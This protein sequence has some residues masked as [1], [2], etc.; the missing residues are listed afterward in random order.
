M[1]READAPI[2]AAYRDDPAINVFQDWDLPY[3]LERATKR[4]AEQAGFDTIIP[5]GWMNLAME[6][7]G[8]LIGDLACHVDE[9][10]HVAEIGYT[11]RAE[12]HGHGFAS[13]GAGA[14]VDHILAT[15]EVH[16]IGASLDPRNIASMRVLEA[17]G[18][19]FESFARQS[20][21]LRGRWDD[22]LR[23]A[24]LRDDRA[25]WLARPRTPP[26]SLE[27]A[28]VTPDDAHLWGRLRTHHSQ[29][30]FVSPMAL[31]FRDALFPEAIDGATVVPW[32]RGVLADGD[33][34]A[35]VMIAEVTEHHPEPYLWRLLVDRMHQRRGVGSR[36][37][38]MLTDRLRAEG[39]TTLLTS[40]GQGRGS[41]EPFYLGLG[42]IPTG[43]VVDGEIEAR[44][45][46]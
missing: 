11:L 33:R 18:M 39:H 25:A 1:M 15:T 34:V 46:L 4:L 2:V 21:A 8:E 7:D 40:W 36:V 5:G 32:M 14:L 30:G 42:F 28:E 16:R 44:L 9:T 27:F 6:L 35:F 38:A 22:D 37:L 31:T 10:G 41:P 19:T 43:R 29:E 45:S 26:S 20:Y 3:T 13:E 24:M 17:I 12:F 23:F